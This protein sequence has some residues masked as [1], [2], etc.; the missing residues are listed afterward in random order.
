MPRAQLHYDHQ[1]RLGVR[2]AICALQ[3]TFASDSRRLQLI[4]GR[5]IGSAAFQLCINLGLDGALN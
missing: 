3:R 2:G 4:M 1:R 5:V